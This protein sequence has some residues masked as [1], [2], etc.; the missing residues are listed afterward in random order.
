MHLYITESGVTLP[1]ELASPQNSMFANKSHVESKIN[2]IFDSDSR[3]L[4]PSIHENLFH[5]AANKINLHHDKYVNELNL[6][7]ALFTT[8]ITQKFLAD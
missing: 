1:M 6:P 3:A 5:F 7:F 4:S 2:F 8:C